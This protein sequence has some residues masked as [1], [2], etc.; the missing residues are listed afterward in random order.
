MTI[1]AEQAQAI[2]E[3]LA[4]IYNR[5]MELRSAKPAAPLRVI[6]VS[7]FPQQPIRS[8]LNSVDGAESGLE[9]AVWLIGETL[10][11]TGGDAAMHAVYSL[12][13]AMLGGRASSWLGHRWSGVTAP[14]ALWIA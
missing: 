10:A 4:K 14:G 11:F 5:V 9:Y 2:A 8:R 13:E 12:F 1:E 7:E 3:R 6:H